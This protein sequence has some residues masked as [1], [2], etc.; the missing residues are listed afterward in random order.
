VG[1][2]VAATVLLPAST[3]LIDEIDRE[4]A[5][6]ED[7][8]EAFAAVRRG[9][10]TPRRLVGAMQHHNRQR[11]GVLG[12]LIEGVQMIGVERLSFGSRGVVVVG[13][14]SGPYGPADGEAALLLDNQRRCVVG[15]A[16]RL[17]C[18]TARRRCED[19]HHGENP[20]SYQPFGSARTHRRSR[21]D[22]LRVT[23]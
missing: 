22:A 17:G 7:R 1:S 23:Q 2:I 12:N 11:P 6:Q 15:S 18:G 8:L 10:P 19:P 3:R 5:A 14:A 21:V 20:N 16:F 4:A 9:F 13:P